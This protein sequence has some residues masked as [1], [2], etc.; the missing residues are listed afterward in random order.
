[1]QAVDGKSPTTEMPR[2]LEQWRNM[3]P[4]AVCEGSSA[5]VLYCVTDA[6][7]TILA[8]ARELNR[9]RVVLD[10]IARTSERAGFNGI[11][12]AAREALS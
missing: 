6:R 7:T 10:D 4:N 12:R 5:Q 1:M 2:T 8:Q 9:L 3:I 11:A